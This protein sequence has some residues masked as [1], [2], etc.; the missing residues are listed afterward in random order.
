MT[1]KLL[2]TAAAAIV[3]VALIGIGNAE[4]NDRGFPG[5]FIPG[6]VIRDRGIHHEVLRHRFIERQGFPAIGFGDGDFT[7]YADPDA[8]VE[9]PALLLMSRNLRL[10]FWR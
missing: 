8:A 9:A 3:L 5:G 4:A 10:L 1:H 7:D 2:M 6:G